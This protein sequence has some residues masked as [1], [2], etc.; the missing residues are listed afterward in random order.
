[1]DARLRCERPSAGQSEA[2]GFQRRR[3]GCVTSDRRSNIAA[4]PRRGRCR[5]TRL[6]RRCAQRPG[7]RVRLGCAP[8][9]TH[10]RHV[11]RLGRR[12]QPAC[13]SRSSRHATAPGRRAA[14]ARGSDARGSRRGGGGRPRRVRRA[15]QRRRRR[16]HGGGDG[17]RRDRP[18]AADRVAGACAAGAS[19]TVA[20]H[21][22]LAGVGGAARRAPVD[23]PSAGALRRDA[24]GGAGRTRTCGSL[25]SS[26]TSGRGWCSVGRVLRW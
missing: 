22:R 5:R 2:R 9:S 11:G 7:R 8:R 6:P 13:R 14:V 10:R 26:S 21:S 17:V 23:R 20:G 3:L 1:M 4:G 24:R 16:R 15:F 18:P 12:C 25:L 19:R